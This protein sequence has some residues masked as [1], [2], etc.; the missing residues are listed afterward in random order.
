MLPR[1]KPFVHRRAAKTAGFS[2]MAS[3]AL[4]STTAY[5]TP[6][7][8]ESTTTGTGDSAD[9]YSTAEVGIYL[10]PEPPK[11]FLFGQN[12]PGFNTSGSG[13]NCQLQK[14]SPDGKF[15]L[16][17]NFGEKSKTPFC[18]F[19][20]DK[21]ASVEDSGTYRIV[22]ETWSGEQLKSAE[23][24][25]VVEHAR[26]LNDSDTLEVPA[27][28]DYLPADESEA[29]AL[30]LET[31]AKT[32][33]WE[34]IAGPELRVFNN[35]YAGLGMPEGTY[36]F[37]VT[38]STNWESISRIVTVHAIKVTDP[39]ILRVDGRRVEQTSVFRGRQNIVDIDPQAGG[40]KWS[41]WG[42]PVGESVQ[43]IK[44]N[45]T[46]PFELPSGEGKWVYQLRVYGPR[47]TELKVFNHELE[48]MTTPVLL[49]TPSF[50]K[51]P[52]ERGSNI[53][54]SALGEVKAH[55]VFLEATREG[56]EN[57]FEVTELRFENKLWQ[58]S[59]DGTKFNGTGKFKTRLKA[60][61][62]DNNSPIYS[63]V[64]ETTVHRGVKLELPTTRI[65]TREG[66]KVTI[67]PQT[68]NARSVLWKK[69]S[70][71]WYCNTDFGVG[72]VLGSG[73]TYTFNEVAKADEGFYEAV[74]IG[75][76]S[77]NEASKKFELEVYSR[78]YEF[79]KPSH[80]IE[81]LS[82][83]LRHIYLLSPGPEPLYW[84]FRPQGSST[85]TKIPNSARGFIM[86][87]NVTA[88]ANSG[89]YRYVM[90]DELFSTP[91]SVTVPPKPGTTAVP[92]PEAPDP[93]T[94]PTSGE[95]SSGT[96]S[97]ETGQPPV[98][99]Q[100]PSSQTSAPT[101]SSPSSGGGGGAFFLLL[102]PL[103]LAAAIW[104]TPL[105]GMLGL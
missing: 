93:N 56:E 12:I 96:R 97:P 78:D 52:S 79:P 85:W 11:D 76:G 66:S 55:K 42:G 95:N 34:Q 15:E 26:F 71:E 99:N 43:L 37:K 57:W 21:Q 80:R 77:G 41:L 49:A 104:F 86:I 53:A 2:L 51:E 3:L 13:R 62:A 105:R 46:G 81:D 82:P 33:N 31:N 28:S 83:E 5:A 14:R 36:K 35:G 63:E 7:A 47:G 25:L 10:W 72:S 16:A 87:T 94:G 100:D 20:L 6:V 32:Q 48:W 101:D 8:S 75:D 44:D 69:C 50:P 18:D 98:Q 17:T 58:A 54:V 90:S 84:E 88:E 70:S 59:F 4:F 89:D 45:L 103:L 67:T 65:L 60:V 27:L 91:V 22:G 64:V 73:D 30:S 24:E 74:A 1:L 19:Y 29:P 102:I 40:A 38:A 23:F 61:G 68:Q 92:K 9:P 39:W